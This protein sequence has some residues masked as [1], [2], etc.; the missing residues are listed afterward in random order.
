M[1]IKTDDNADLV[2]ESLLYKEFL[3][4]REE[5]LRHKWIESEKAGH[6][7]GFEKALL[8]WIVKHRSSWRSQRQSE[9]KVGS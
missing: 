7:I 8:D 2:K 1:S 5:I 4:E 6:D 9:H 3:A